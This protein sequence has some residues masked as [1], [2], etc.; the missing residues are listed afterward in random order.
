MR[1]TS[2]LRGGAGAE[3]RAS[4][5]GGVPCGTAGEMAEGGDRRG[6]RDRLWGGMP[7]SRA[8]AHI[9]PR[10]C[11]RPLLH[12]PASPNDMHRLVLILCLAGTLTACDSGSDAE[13]VAVSG[14]VTN[15]FGLPVS[16]ATVSFDAG[17]GAGKTAPTV[18]TDRDGRYTADLDAGAYTVTVT[19]NG[20]TA[21]TFSATAAE[22]ATVD[23]TISGP[24]TVRG[25]V[26]NALT[27]DVLPDATVE[28]VFQDAAGENPT[29]APVE[30]LTQTD[31]EGAYGFSGAPFGTYVCIVTVPD[32]PPFIVRDVVFEAS[33]ETDL[34]QGVV[35]PLPAAG[36]YRIVLTWGET[37]SDLDT[38][39]TGP[40]GQ[41]DERFHIYYSS[42]SP[43]NAGGSNL[44]VD[45]VT[46]FG[47]ETLTL[48]PPADGVYRYSVFNY[49]DQSSSGA[50]GIATSEARVEVY[51]TAGLV[52]TY[53]PPAAAGDDG[54]TWRVFEMT[55]QDGTVAF[56][57]SVPNGIGYVDAAGSSDI[58]SFFRDLPAKAIAY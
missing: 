43:S 24:A 36:E 10:R 1:G 22:G 41:D 20:Y 14:T 28:F 23:Q 58:G 55:I 4:G 12:P 57:G 6:G 32:Q 2:P 35:T 49:S 33:G 56:T 7:Y 40:T 51:D 21:A 52:R 30:V 11:A 8:E 47:P 37:P 29:D 13:R 39:M 3:G 44:D 38:H 31:A 19:K 45:D 46:S 18:T 15:A 16:S 5:V 17:N 54:N 53:T 25:S 42:R 9:G 27:G 26:V 50:D 48:V 34:G